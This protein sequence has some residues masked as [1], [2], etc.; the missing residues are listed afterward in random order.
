MGEGET[1]ARLS[2]RLASLRAALGDC[3]LRDRRRLG[4]WLGRLAKRGPA[5]DLRE[6]ERLEAQVRGSAERVAA[7]R[8]SLPVVRY[9]ESLPVHARREEIAAAIRRSPVTI[10]SGATGSGKSTQLPKICLE[11]GRGVAGMIGHTQPRRIAA[12]TLAYRVSAELGTTPGD[13][14]G[15]QVRFVDRT[16]PRTLVKLMTDGL[17]LRELEASLKDPKHSPQTKG[18]M[19][20]VKDFAKYPEI[21]FL[22]RHVY[23]API[24][25]ALVLYG[26]GA[27]FERA[28]PAWDTSGWQMV[29]WG[30]FISTVLVYHV[31]FCINSLMHIIGNRRFQTNDTSRNN[32]VLALLSMGEGWHNNHH[33]YAASVRQGFF[34]W[35]V[36]LTYYVLRLL[37]LPRIVW[38][39]RE[40][41]ARV[42]EEAG[43]R[44]VAQQG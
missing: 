15:Y 9:D 38:D 34:W 18:W 2:E 37:A 33:R 4:G 43:A 27:W 41:S 35:E 10:V 8:S 39:L 12:Q 23:F 19:D 7:R 17:L 11:L 16:G 3:Q 14:V 20:R 42:L 44:R 1:G 13:L 40:P 29:V 22:D 25:L 5:L 30:F 24:T 26:L 31:T 6:L 28:R 36:D 32:F 21:R